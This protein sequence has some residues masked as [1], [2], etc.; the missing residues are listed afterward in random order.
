MTIMMERRL[1]LKAGAFGL[2]ALATPGV[3]QLLTARGFTHGVASGEPSANSV[4]LWV[5]YVGNGDVPLTCEVAADQNFTRIVGG[6]TITAAAEHDH[7][8]KLVVSG[9][10]PNH[11]F[12]YRFVAPDGT[13]SA[14]GR[15]RTLPDGDTPRFGIG[16]FSCS[17]MP[18][19][20]FN[21]YAHAAA[22]D[23]LDLMVHVG[24]YLYE[25]GPGKYP[26]IEVPGR[27]V[28]PDHEMV[29]LA[30]YRLRYAAY[31]LDPDLLRLH[32]RFPMLAQWDD[33]EFANDSWQGGAENHQPDTEGDWSA[34]KAVAERVYREWMP[35]SDKRYDSYQIGS[36]ATLFRPETRITARS[37]QLE[38]GEALA[39]RSDIAKAFADFRDGPWSAANRTLMGAEQEA[40]LYRGFE[41]SVKTGTRW[42]ILA[43][44]IVMGSIRAPEAIAGWTSTGSPPE[45][46]KAMMGI[47]AASKAGLPFNMDAW[48][49]YPAARERL[50]RA[51]QET[52]S[53]LVV[54]SGD[55]HNAWANNLSTGGRAAGVEYAG[56]AVTSPGFET[57]LPSVAPTD[58]ARA[59]R[60]TNPDLRY[61]DTSRR[62]YVSLQISPDQVRGEFHFVQTI[63]ARTTVGVTSN[64]LTVRWGEKR[65]AAS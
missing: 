39:G 32:Q 58:F 38:L 55:S 16:L 14:I 24:D 49:G 4:L 48:D 36:L 9:L 31:R 21:A 53:N 27:T 51:A 18:F 46:R 65:F 25:Y 11:W 20:W 34:R 5:R 33:H 54:L 44:Q 29:T 50:L 10:T 59:L 13:K 60:E 7:C 19:G 62:G 47:V 52:D 63:S 57:Y 23:D 26:T 2:A 43:Q 17:N 1:L 45:V 8:A 56:H 28:Q 22:R 40:W 3:A 41:R 12:F 6:G 42:Q 37:E 35:V 30:D 15:T 61:S 64:N